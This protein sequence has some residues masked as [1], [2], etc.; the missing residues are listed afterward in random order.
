MSNIL[1]ISVLIHAHNEPK[2]K[3]KVLAAH[4]NFFLTKYK[5][6]IQTAQRLR[7]TFI[8]GY[9]YFPTYIICTNWLFY[10]PSQS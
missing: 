4:S 3:E 6:C 9:Y 1:N 5:V 8:S 10:S 2:L 7:I